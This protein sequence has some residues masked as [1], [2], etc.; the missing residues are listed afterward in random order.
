MVSSVN[1]AGVSGTSSGLLS[2]LTGGAKPLGQD[3]FMKL[4]IAQIQHQDPLKPM[5][6]TAFVAQLAQFSSL[7]QQLSTNKLLELMTTQQ[8]GLANNTVIDLV[9]RNVTVRGSSTTLD[10]TG[11]GT[12]VSFTLGAPAESVTV[13][14]RNAAGDTV[15]TIEIGAKPAGLASVHWDGKNNQG[16]VQP[17]GSYSVVVQAKGQNGAEIDVSQETSSTVQSISFD[18]GYAMLMLSNGVSAPAADLIQVNR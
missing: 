17:A 7:E 13:A 18:K 10:S 1:S 12:P 4:L 9:G 3:A 14:I 8:K 6:D 2:S 15:R 16:I 5:D 11:L